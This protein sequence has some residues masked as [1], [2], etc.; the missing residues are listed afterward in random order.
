ML[1]L[2]RRSPPACV[3]CDIVA[4]IQQPNSSEQTPSESPPPP[5]SSPPA[6][7]LQETPSI[8]AIADK[9]PAAKHHFLVMPKEHIVNA[10][11]LTADHV[12]LWEEM[13]RVGK[14]LV[15]SQI[16]DETER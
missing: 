15:Q 16:E 13:T 10:K 3:F 12:A 9:F 6:T 2:F 14:E 8:L 1:S 11:C 7:I 5:P 4:S